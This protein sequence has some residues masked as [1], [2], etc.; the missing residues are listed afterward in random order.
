MPAPRAIR[1]PNASAMTLD[2][3]RTYLV[4]S[5]RVAIID[6]GPD[7]PGHL[8]AVAAAVGDARVVGVLV[9]H[10]HPDHMPG[11]ARLGEFFGA[12]VL[13][14]SH[15]NLREGDLFGTDAG[16]LMTMATPGHSPDHLSFY[17]INARALF[18]GD[19][20]LGGLDTALVAP[21]EG[22]L[23]R[24]LASLRRLRDL[25]PAII[26]PAHGEPFTDAPAAI[27]SYLRHRQERQQAILDFL[28]DGPAAQDA[29]AER[30]YGA[31]LDPQL[32]QAS[33]GST[34]G[35]LEHLERLGRV[36]QERGLWELVP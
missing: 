23:S 2:G 34:L 24:Y 13:S 18:C 31:S 28:A 9:S 3:T 1:A 33:L 7:L 29:I 21:P 25:Q 22:D 20:M 26:Y 16:G 19:L 32:A 17:W 12:R 10:D 11:A 6:P 30:V 4:G 14:A 8:A 27:E 5:R 35:Y 15:G 36:Q